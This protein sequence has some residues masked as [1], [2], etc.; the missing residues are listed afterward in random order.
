MITSVCDN[1][2]AILCNASL[3]TA[4][5]WACV[6]VCVLSHS[7][8]PAALAPVTHVHT[9][10]PETLQNCLGWAQ[11]VCMLSVIPI[12]KSPSIASCRIHCWP[13]EHVSAE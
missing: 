4:F 7:L 6:C 13:E 11:Q 9:T 2:F 12:G 8:I 1:L 3:L 5:K 10:K